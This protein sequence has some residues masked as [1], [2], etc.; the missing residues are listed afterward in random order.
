MFAPQ[1]AHLLCHPATPCA[2]LDALEVSIEPGATGSLVLRYRGQGRPA[3]LLIPS[4]RPAGPAD[5][6][7]QHTCCEAFVAAPDNKSYRE[8][9]FSPSNQWAVYDF[10]ACRE[11]DAGYSPPDAPRIT[12]QPLADG[13]ELT[14]ELGPALLPADNTLRLGLS[15]VIEMADGSK[16]YWALAHCAAQ[17]DFHR[18]DSFT[19][20]LNRNTP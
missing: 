4:P 12:M 16:S 14:A 18:R 6:L 7:W 10:A 5:N 2:A 1:I 8:F 11:R 15:A 13:F 17:P 9:N 19:L 3:A 20:S